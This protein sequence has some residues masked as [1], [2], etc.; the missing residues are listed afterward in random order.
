MGVAGNNSLVAKGGSSYLDGGTG[1][2]DGLFDGS[3]SN[4]LVGTG[5]NDTVVIRHQADLV[6]LTGTGNTAISSVDLYQLP[7]NVSN[8]FLNVTPQTG[9]S[10]QVSLDGQR[11]TAGYAAVS[12]AKGGNTGSF[13]TKFGEAPS[14]NSPAAVRLQVT[15]GTSDGTT[16]GSDN[17]PD[18]NLALNVGTVTADPKNPGKQ[19]VTLSWAT[20]LDPDGNPVG[21]TMGYLV[22][23]Q[24]VATDVGGTILSSTP[25]LTYLQGT[26]QDLTGTSTNPQLLVDNLSSS[27]TDPYTGI[28]YDSSNSTISYNFKVT[29]QE[30]VL[31]AYTDDSGN[32]IGK[33]VSLIGGQG[34][35]VLYGDLLDNLG[36]SIS[37]TR[38]VLTNNPI[39]PLDPGTIPTPAPW[40]LSAN[41]YGVFP[42]YLNGGLDGNDLLIAPY[43]HDGSGQDFTAYE[44]INGVP[45]PVTYSGINTLVGGFGSDT[46]VVFNG[47]TTIDTTNGIVTTGA[48]DQVQKFGNETASG[49][50]N[51]IVSGVQYLTLSDTDVSQGKFID[52]AWAPYSG[53]YVGGNRLDNT[54]SSYGF[55]NTLLGGGGRDSLYANL[56]AFSFNPLLLIGGTAYG[57]DSISGALADYANGQTSSIYRD[58]DPVPPGVNGPGAADNSQYWIVNGLYDPNRNSDTLVVAGG[59]EHDK[60]TL[61]GGAGSDSMVG[62]T[63]D[64]YFY[65]SSGSNSHYYPS[66]PRLSADVVIGSGGNDT[67]I[68][69]GSDVYWS[70]IAGSTSSILS[71][72]LSNDG[73]AASGQSIS[74]IKLQ[75][76]SPVARQATGNSTST[77]NQH[78][79]KLGSETGSN[80][81]VGNEQDNILNGGGVGGKDETGVGCDTLTG[82]GG[83]DTFVISGYRK[84]N[85]NASAAFTDPNNTVTTY[86]LT[87]YAT[88]ADYTY[89]SDFGSDDILDLSG[90]KSL[91]LIGSAPSGSN[92]G[93][94]SN[95][96][97]GGTP[98]AGS[99]TFGIYYAPSKDTPNLV[100]VIK[101]DGG[102]NLGGNLVYQ[103]FGGINVDGQNS[104]LG[105]DALTPGLASGDATGLNYLGFGA[106]YK[107]DGSDFGNK[108][109]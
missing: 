46:F 97:S 8:F 20:L 16:Y 40:S 85:K 82:L 58:T 36:S 57:L 2:D 81:I 62:G 35:D 74:N 5:G 105:G 67:V 38:P 56:S 49:Q 104:H 50:H 72:V 15:Y 93:F 95:N 3:G 108:V 23:Y 66:T 61:D 94:S 26:S 17:V 45:T 87:S 70:G 100:A 107:L 42:T 69:T 60:A 64:D 83:A 33:P 13:T 106:M 65:V 73:D 102:L 44:Y 89:I 18:A 31:P 43:L 75:D 39:N 28:T 37:N 79:G 21:Q 55:N 68:F 103:N 80:L 92:A 91:Y 84:S 22:N 32:L 88:D 19:A 53:Q 109:I 52:Q 7:D 24:L 47:G 1:Y 30:R 90:D 51:L 54:L 71:F 6:S 9:N 77:G 63:G 4:T 78:N 59:G 11:M 96:I 25:Y 101:C 10:G 98:T 86:N 41:W 12:N 14:L 48:Y 27:F 29:A 99:T 76:G 34:N